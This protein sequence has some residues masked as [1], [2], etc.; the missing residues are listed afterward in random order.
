MEVRK[1]ENETIGAMLYRFNKKVKQ[2]GV[3]KELKKRR[4]EKRS[5]NRGKRKLAALYRSKK[6]EELE[7][8]KKYGIAKSD[9]R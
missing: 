3:M 6:A 5:L 9:K 1:R 8:E 2:G 4:F 7:M